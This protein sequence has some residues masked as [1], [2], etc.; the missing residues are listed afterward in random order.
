M[1]VIIKCLKT[2]F[3]IRMLKTVTRV[4]KTPSFLQISI[5]KTLR[6]TT[7]DKQNSKANRPGQIYIKDQI[8]RTNDE[9]Y[10]KF[11]VL[12]FD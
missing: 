1:T 11:Y 5:N 6:T 4:M 10:K 8:H 12:T 9:F 7:V 2:F 3:Q